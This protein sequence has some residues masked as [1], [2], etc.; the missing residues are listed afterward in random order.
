MNRRNFLNILGGGTILAAAGSAG[1][2]FSRTPTKALEPWA[3]ATTYTDPIKRA[4]AHA[5]LAPNPHNRQPWLV[6]LSQE[7]QVTIHRDTTRDL[8]MTDPFNRQIFIGM[9]CFL[10]TLRIAATETG[11]V[12]DFDILPQGEDVPIAVAKFSKGA[13]LDPLAEFIVTRHSDKQAYE[14]RD[15]EADKIAALSNYV[16]I[17]TDQQRVEAL[18]QITW[19]ALEIEML[20]PHTLKESVDLMRIGKREINANPD[21]IEMREPML[22]ALYNLGLLKRE[23]LLDT[24]HSGFRAKMNAMQ[25]TCF[26]TPAFAVLTTQGNTRHDQINAGRDWMRYSLA[27]TS[28]GLGTQP[29][30]QAL[31]EYPEVATQYDQVHQML[32]KDGE[33]VQMLARVGYGSN[34]I[35]TPRWALETRIVNGR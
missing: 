29:M 22:D 35:A 12:V 7:G 1:F 23:M 24:D 26:A 30:S 19:D 27:A 16:S 20:T 18:R 34:A 6:D 28:M 32:A 17:I 8:P 2:L 5:L 9:G 13:T 21:G 10:E 14:D 15:I 31:Q 3:G 25:R 11:H 4:L 33:T